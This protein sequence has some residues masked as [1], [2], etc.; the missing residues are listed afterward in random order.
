MAEWLGFLWR[1]E[2]QRT[3]KNPF[4]QGQELNTTFDNMCSGIETERYVPITY[5]NC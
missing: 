5:R 3:W 4:K 2:N 1:E